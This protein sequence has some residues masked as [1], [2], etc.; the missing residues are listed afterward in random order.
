MFRRISGWFLAIVLCLSFFSFVPNRAEAA[1]ANPNFGFATGY[2]ILTMSEADMNAWLNGIAATGAKYIRFDF[3]WA[4]VQSGGSGSYNWS[5]TDRVV[6]A[7]LA[8]GL[9]ILPV[10]SH[11]T[12]WAG[13]PST[14]NPTDF[15]NFVYNLGLRY[16]PKG[17][18][19]YEMWNE[20]NIQ[21]FS[22]ANY[23]TKILIPG[24]NGIRQAASQLGETVTVVTT[25][26]APA[27][28]NGTHWSMLDYVTGIYANG[29]KNYF[30][31]LGVHPYTWPND[32][33]VM[34][35]WNWLLKTPELYDVMAAN[36]DGHK[37]LWVT[38]NGYP[39][40]ATNGVTEAQQAQ[41]MED[42][43]EIWKSFPFAGGPYLMYAYKD[44]GTDV[45]DPEDFFGIVRHNGTLKPAHATVVN[46]IASNPPASPSSTVT[47]LN[48]TSAITVD[49]NLNESG[50]TVDTSV[51]KGLSGTPNNTAAYDVMWNNS[52]LYV[53]VKVLDGN[54]YKDSANSWE[55]DSVEIYIDPGHNH[56]TAYEA[57]DR[58]FMKGYNNA[59]LF[60]KNNNTSGV[61]HGWAPIAGGYSVE[62]AIPWSNLGIAPT[63]GA[64]IGFDIGINDDDNGGTR[65]S[66]LV[67][68]GTIMNW[69]DT[70]GF[71]DAVLSAT[72][73]GGAVTYYKIQNRWKDIQFLYDGGTRVNYGN[74]AGDA[75]LWSLETYNGYTRIRNK[76]TG[77]YIHIKNGATNVESTAIAASDATS[78][79]TIASSSATTTAKSIKSASNNSYINNET[80]LGYVTCDRTTVP[81]D[82]AWS[83]EQWFFV[84]Q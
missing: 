79:W 22:P 78:H 30:D 46:M 69:T 44:L 72:P 74:G 10:V 20:A 34:T 15:R 5:Q 14:M 41:Y 53:G 8:K 65:D 18:T 38:E 80:Q 61:L 19:A 64:T 28:T 62:L 55:D 71:G 59:A 16:I 31:A 42:A 58:Q 83:S 36:G 49:G 56:T 27:A 76:A 54:L 50:W 82:T 84:Q 43:Y 70:S 7:A 51:S 39:T 45:T 57:N 48:V 47:A 26:L 17:I 60:E 40:S 2:S 73:T 68:N 1:A 29:G 32:P 23:V 77:E 81:S 9:S 52:Y 75:Y 21:G 11:L 67:W 12:G 24:A 3:S 66:Q 25:G 13:S 33:T 6:D 37:K 4:Y 35:N 63:S